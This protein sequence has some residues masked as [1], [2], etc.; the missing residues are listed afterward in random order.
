[1][2]S[3]DNSNDKNK[4]VNIYD[5]GV[6]TS[7]ISDGAKVKDA[8]EKSGIILNEHDRV[9]PGLDSEI[10]NDTV[11]LNNTIHILSVPLFITVLFDLSFFNAMIIVSAIRYARLSWLLDTSIGSTEVL[12]RSLNYPGRYIT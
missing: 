1:M 3:T 7:V 8:I 12:S 6:K 9:E 11:V 10:S 2:R 5:R 4:L